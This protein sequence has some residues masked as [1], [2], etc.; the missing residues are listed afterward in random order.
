MIVTGLLVLEAYP[1]AS[2]RGLMKI[3]KIVLCLSQILNIS[4]ALAGEASNI[5]IKSL[6]ESFRIPLKEIQ[7]IESVTWSPDGSFLIL[8][9][10]WRNDDNIAHTVL[11]LVDKTVQPLDDV[12]KQ[13]TGEEVVLMEVRNT[14]VE[15][16]F[17][18]IRERKRVSKIYR[19]SV[20]AVMGLDGA[21]FIIIVYERPGVTYSILVDRASSSEIRLEGKGLWYTFTRDGRYIIEDQIPVARTN[22]LNSKTGEVVYSFDGSLKIDYFPDLNFLLVSKHKIIE[23]YNPIEE[24]ISKVFSLDSLTYVSEEIVGKMPF[25]DIARPIAAVSKGLLSMGIRTVANDNYEGIL[26]DLEKKTTTHTGGY[27]LNGIHFAGYSTRDKSI[28]L[29]NVRNGGEPN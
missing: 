20:N 27:T 21:Q 16:Y 13:F 1:S 14:L 8:N 6:K 25:F 24:S 3:L 23:P 19:G 18:N 5:E 7:E 26:I 17:Y 10:D 29:L 9:R 11:N 12:F 28:I 2:L 15:K 4:A 22:I